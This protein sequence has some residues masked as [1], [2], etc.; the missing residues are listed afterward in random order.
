[1]EVVQCVDKLA[2]ETFDCKIVRYMQTR[3]AV[4]LALQVAGERRA[5]ESEEMPVGDSNA[6][7]MRIR[8]PGVSCQGGA[9]GIESEDGAKGSQPETTS[10]G[11]MFPNFMNRTQEIDA[12]SILQLCRQEHCFIPAEDLELATDCVAVG[13]FWQITAGSWKGTPIVAKQSKALFGDTS[14][15][16]LNILNE[17]RMLRLIRHP[18]LLQLFGVA[19]IGPTKELT[20]IVE[21]THAPA[22]VMWLRSPSSNEDDAGPPGEKERL[23]VLLQICR[24]LRHLHTHVPPIVHGNLKDTGVVVEEGS[25][26]PKVK[27]LEFGF[28]QMLTGSQVHATGDGTWRYKAPELWQA[29]A[30]PAP[31]PAMDSFAFGGLMFLLASG[32]KPFSD[33]TSDEMFCAIRKGRSVHPNWEDRDF[34]HGVWNSLLPACLQSSPQDRPGMHDIHAALAGHLQRASVAA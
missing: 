3:S 33:I 22:L 27:I 31:T 20:L 4:W 5:A 17:L 1:M 19:T 21:V 13:S 12:N 10:T 6:G 23:L 34:S 9:D 2:G 15:T 8:S 29:G 14:H 16:R 18:C 32:K 26:F 7:S 28:A 30:L 24:V 11:R 25:P